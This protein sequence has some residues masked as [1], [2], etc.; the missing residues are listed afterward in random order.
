VAEGGLERVHISLPDLIV[1]AR[2]MNA[3]GIILMQNRPGPVVHDVPIDALVT[4]KIAL[5]CELLGMPLVD[6]IYINSH[7][8]AFFGRERGLFK[9]VPELLVTMRE[10]A[11]DLAIK[12]WETGLCED[13][14]YEKKKAAE[15][16]MARAKAKARGAVD[17]TTRKRR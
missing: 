7:G 14:Y 13:D 6:H 3:A 1:K 10:G 2:M 15:R 17:V 4:I 5:V 11:E 16:E 12:A 8:S 9:K